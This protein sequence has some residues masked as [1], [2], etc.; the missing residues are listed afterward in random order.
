MRLG[1][2]EVNRLGFGAMR[3]CGPQIWGP[4]ADRANALAVLRRACELGHNF[5][6]TA[7]SY[8]PEVS[9]SLI[10]EAL[11]PYPRD[12]VIGTKGGLVRPS[13][14][15]WDPDGRPEHLR[16]ALEGS[17]KRLRLE[18]IDLYQLHA[19]DPKVPFAESFGALAAMQKAGKIRHLG[20]SNVSVAQLEQARDIAP[21]V[22]VQNSYNLDNRSS[23]PVLRACER[24]GIAFLP[25]YPLAAGAALRSAKVKRVAEKRNA[26]PA[27]VCIAWLLAKSPAML[28]IPGTGSLAHLEEN[29]AAARLRL[30][31]EDVTALDPAT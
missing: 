6:D 20:L 26:T 30:A 17:L 15:R 1:D 11:Y 4:P 9:E 25:W 16:R 19:P 21:V 23:E 24:L 14:P 22:S 27:Q 5:F 29:A 31:P 28:P 8:G 18:R 7:D 13:A 10:A 2:L 12:L 3:V